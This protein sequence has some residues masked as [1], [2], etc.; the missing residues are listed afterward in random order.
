MNLPR[1]LSS[2]IL[3]LVVVALGWVPARGQTNVT[4]AFYDKPLELKLERSIKRKFSSY[5]RQ[6]ASDYYRKRPFDQLDREF[7]SNRLVQGRK[8]RL[9][10]RAC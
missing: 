8:V 5:L 4:D 2:I 7:L 3:V 6:Q 10:P 9:L 1:E